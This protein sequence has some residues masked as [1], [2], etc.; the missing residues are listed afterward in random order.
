VIESPHFLV[1]I[2]PL[3]FSP[4]L[5]WVLIA[6]LDIAKSPTNLSHWVL[7]PIA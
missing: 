7:A 4:G 6:D 5:T 1:V 2:A 3:E